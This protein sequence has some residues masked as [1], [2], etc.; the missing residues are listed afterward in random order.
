MFCCTI[1]HLPNFNSWPHIWLWNILLYRGA[2]GRL[3]DRPNHHPPSLQWFSQKCVAV[4]SNLHFSP[5]SE[6]FSLSRCN[7]ACHAAVFLLERRG[8]LFQ[9]L[10]YPFGVFL[11]V[12][13]W[14][15]TFNMLSETCR[16]WGGALGVSAVS[17]RADASPAS[18]FHS[19]RSLH[20]SLARSWLASGMASSPLPPALSCFVSETFGFL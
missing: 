17:L 6:S 7:F 3:S 13:S 5:C 16:V 8:F 10:L 2:H 9:T 14:I 18:Y 15:L 19:I 4:H 1:E 12:L 20:L 11:I